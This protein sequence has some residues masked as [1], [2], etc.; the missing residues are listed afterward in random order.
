M[1]DR[2]LTI[3]CALAIIMVCLGGCEKEDSHPT[4]G[5]AP[6]AEQA[7]PDF[8]SFCTELERLLS[9][10]ADASILNPRVSECHERV[11]KAYAVVDSPEVRETTSGKYLLREARA[12]CS[13]LALAAKTYDASRE[14]TGFLK[15]AQHRI[16]LAHFAGAQAKARRLL[17]Q[18][19]RIK[20]GED[21]ASIL[22]DKEPLPVKPKIEIIPDE[23]PKITVVSPTRDLLVSP[24]EPVMIR[25][26]VSVD[27]GLAEAYLLVR[28]NK[29]KNEV[30]HTF[31]VNGVK[32]KRLEYLFRVP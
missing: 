22:R 17:S 13:D 16:V 7:V 20:R 19:E 1:T 21:L 28:K 18:H 15:D 12:I 10:N 8:D 30:L 32:K 24:I 11:K 25:A 23:P 3:S 4:S 14:A 6:Q 5:V 29:G 9:Y 26:V 31:D 2:T 27:H